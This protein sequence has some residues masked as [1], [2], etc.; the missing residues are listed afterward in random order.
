MV[1]TLLMRK[2]LKLTFLNK[3]YL[4]LEGNYFHFVLTNKLYPV[5]FRIIIISDKVYDYDVMWFD[6]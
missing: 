1:F 5:L 2:L 3:F 4:Y 6:L